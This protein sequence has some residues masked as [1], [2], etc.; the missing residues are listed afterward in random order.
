MQKL[1]AM[2]LFGMAQAFEEQLQQPQFT[3]LSFEDRLTLLV[4]RQWID[5]EDRALRTRLTFSGLKQTA[6]IE[7]IDYRS[8][9]GFKRAQIEQLARCEWVRYHQNCIISGPTGVGKS[10]IGCALA[11]KACREG[12]RSLY[13]YEPRL[14]RQLQIAQADGSMVKLLKKIARV[15]LLL[16]DD[17]G[18]SKVHD[19]QRS[20]H[21]GNKERFRS[22]S[23]SHPRITRSWARYPA[24]SPKNLSGEA[25]LLV[26]RTPNIT[27]PSTI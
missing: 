15:D 9:R 11:Q 16:I 8:A 1:N 26:S 23:Q 21:S 19:T 12:Y 4:E 18:I 20:P 10:F 7:D 27:V 25:T 3:E 14:L 2:K 22:L 24:Q 6:C 17:W 5:K 13:F